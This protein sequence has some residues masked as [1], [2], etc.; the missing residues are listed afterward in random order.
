M[1]VNLDMIHDFI[2]GDEMYVLCESRTYQKYTKCT[3]SGIRWLINDKR[4]PVLETPTPESVF[5]TTGQS[6][7]QYAHCARCKSILLEPD[8]GHKPGEII[9]PRP[10]WIRQ[11]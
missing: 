5:Y 1:A 8:W 6:G 10:G 4:W 3:H 7:T 9:Y 11:D 2:D